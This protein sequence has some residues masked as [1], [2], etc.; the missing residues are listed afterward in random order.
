MRFFG[1]KTRNAGGSECAN[2]LV[3]L[4]SQEWRRNGPKGAD[5]CP[6]KNLDVSRR[7]GKRKTWCGHGC[8]TSL[9]GLQQRTF[10]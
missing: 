5:G 4:E 8:Q 6:A 2:L 3:V 9:E 10:L 1:T 7:V